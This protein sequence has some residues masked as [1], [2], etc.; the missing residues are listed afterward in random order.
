MVAIPFDDDAD[1]IE[2]ANNSLYGLACGIWTRDYKRAWSTARKID[3]G[4]VWINTYKMLS[5]AAPFGGT[6]Q[7]GLGREKGRTWIHDYMSQK[8]IYWGTN[9]CP[10]QWSD[11]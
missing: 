2:Q 8:S 1:L 7:S 3:A 6:K 4:T 11:L 9:E 10:F 5:S